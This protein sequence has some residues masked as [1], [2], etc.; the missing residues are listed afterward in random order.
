MMTYSG[1]YMLLCEVD[2]T[3][4]LSSQK[5][6]FKGEGV[7]EMLRY[8]IF[9]TCIGTQTKTTTIPLIIIAKNIVERVYLK[10]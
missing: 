10:T 2:Q 7:K 9:E 5:Q 8:F 4:W 3:P 1:S 6:R